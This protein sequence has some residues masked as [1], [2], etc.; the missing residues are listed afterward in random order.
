MRVHVSLND[1][2]GHASR[3][4]MQCHKTAEARGFA[5]QDMH[6][7]AH[8]CITFLYQSTSADH[9]VADARAGR[10]SLHSSAPVTKA[11]YTLRKDLD[12]L[13]I[14]ETD[15]NLHELWFCC[16]TLYRQAWDK[17]YNADTGYKKVYHPTEYATG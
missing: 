11:A 16:P 14:G 1:V 6:F 3:D 15:K 10:S 7:L 9:A 4:H 2:H 17:A 12:G 8:T 5:L 13:V